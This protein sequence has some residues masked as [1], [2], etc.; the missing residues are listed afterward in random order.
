MKNN[1]QLFDTR[2]KRCQTFCFKEDNVLFLRGNSIKI[3]II[4]TMIH[5]SI[6]KYVHTQMRTHM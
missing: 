3:T 6:R 5:M 2:V 1:N 4:G